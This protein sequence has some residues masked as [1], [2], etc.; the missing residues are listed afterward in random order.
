MTEANEL[1]KLEQLE[2]EVKELKASRDYWMDRHDEVSRK[3][4]ALRDSIKSVIVL[5]D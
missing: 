1:T 5:V 2:N 3:F 4:N